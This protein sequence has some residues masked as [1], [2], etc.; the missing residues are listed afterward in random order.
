MCIIEA[1]TDYTHLWVELGCVW[2]CLDCW[3]E[4]W[5]WRWAVEARE[6]GPHL[7]ALCLEDRCNTLAHPF[8]LT[9]CNNYMLS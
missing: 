6:A 5:Q 7:G 2:S 3:C 4:R 8:L 1:T 9:I